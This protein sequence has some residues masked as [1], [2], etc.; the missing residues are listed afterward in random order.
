MALF[1]YATKEI[2]LK[3]VYYGPGLSGK[4]TNLQ[5][6]HATLD[7]NTK[8]KLL[9]LST[10]ADRTLFFDFLPVEIGR[11]KDFSIRF[12]L[13]TVP[14][15]VRYNATRKIVLKGAD[16]VV[17]VADSQIE[18][19]EQ[20]LDGIGNMMDNLRSNNIN[21]DEI[22]IV[23]QYNKRDLPNL[24]SVEELNADLNSKNYPVIKASALN[25]NGV[26]E[27]YELIVRLLLKNISEKHKIEIQT[28][29]IFEDSGKQSIQEPFHEPVISPPTAEAPGPYAEAT[30]S[31]AVQE[32]STQMPDVSY[33]SAE[34]AHSD[35][36]VTE[37]S[38]VAAPVTE[39]SL[40][41]PQDAE[42]P[43]AIVQPENQ[44]M[45]HVVSAGSLPQPEGEVPDTV[46]EEPPVV[47]SEKMDDIIDEIRT[48]NAILPKIHDSFRTISKQM[49][50]MRKELMGLSELQKRRESRDLKD[51]NEMKKEHQD[52][53]AMLRIIVTSLER[54]KIK[55]GWFRW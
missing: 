41:E 20:N 34:H 28:V 24:L 30:E 39:R 22:P 19:K 32:E 13:Y 29:D 26:R 49:A 6:L 5:Y 4:T 43:A 40:E 2:T 44:P 14:G 38:H 48:V 37:E 25:G 33:K 16:A 3:I 15:Q 10:E 42:Q 52:T 17:F 18:M 53:N 55:K 31:T 47:V 51:I 9:S 12:Q 50:M 45:E 23:L 1:N 8:G 11:I 21:P 46:R 7:P 35:I 27:A 36:N 54:L